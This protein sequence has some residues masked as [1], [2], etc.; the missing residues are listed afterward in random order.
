[1]NR[2]IINPNRPDTWEIQ[3]KEGTNHLGRGDATDFKIADDSVSSS[4]CHILV[5]NGE[6]SIEDLGSTN[7]TFINGEPVQNAKLHNGQSV[8]LG[9]VEM[10]FYADAPQSKAAATAAP[11]L[12][13]P[14]LNHAP[15]ATPTESAEA[16]P[17]LAPAF[18]L[19]AASKFCKF[20][21]KNLAYRFCGK[22]G[23]S[24]CDL[25]VNTH[26]I[27][28]SAKKICR[29][30][31]VECAPLEA[32]VMVSTQTGFM[33]SLPGAFVYPFRGTGIL[34]LIF[35][36]LLFA[37]LGASMAGIFSIIIKLGAIGYLFSYM[38]NIIHATANEETEMPELP[39][40]D[41]LFGGFVRLAGTV[42]MSFGLAFGLL[43]ARLFEVDIPVSAIIVAMIFGCI[44]FPMAFLAVAMKDNVMA[45]N[46]LVVLP[47]ILRVPGP[48]LV[49]FI[50]LASIF[51]VQ[52]IGNLVSGAAGSAAFTTTSMSVMFMSFGI[53][54]VWSFIGVYLLTV[55]MRIM[56]L[57][58]LTQKEKLDWF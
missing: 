21:P 51:G 12:R 13:I 57:L 42:V 7:G 52:Q 29:T 30:C 41:D 20:H 18:D 25:C 44:Y 31:A 58:Y 38:Q 27:G 50:L 55:N 10:L 33:A 22:C 19:K 56:G 23:C 40:M 39:G 36:T 24:F 32:E 5:V 15:V 43:V 2:L 9:T 35:S 48:Y 14:G 1:M 16:P 26:T 34:I 3:L 47:S 8:R 46:P 49:A 11:R 28:G 6:V 37:A 53:R 54:M 45:S 4:H 17:L